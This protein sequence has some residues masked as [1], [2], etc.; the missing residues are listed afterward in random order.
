MLNTSSVA[1]TLGNSLG[2]A[3]N[4]KTESPTSSSTVRYL[5]ESGENM[6]TQRK[7]FTQVFTATLFIVAKNGNNRNSINR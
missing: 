5:H 7:T 3:Q 6:S 4:L 2:V 1:A